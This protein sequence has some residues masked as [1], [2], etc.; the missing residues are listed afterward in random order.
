[1]TDN[2]IIGCNERWFPTEHGLEESPDD[3]GYLCLRTVLVRGAVEDCAAYQGIGS[4]EWVR[5]FGNKV[6]EAEALI[7]FPRGF[8]GLKYRWP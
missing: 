5:R 3:E 4:Q 8:G 1:M 6:S 2:N 7:H